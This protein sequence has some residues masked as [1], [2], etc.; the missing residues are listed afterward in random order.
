MREGELILGGPLDVIDPKDSFRTA[1]GHKAKSQLLLERGED[2]G[3][4]VRHS[5]VPLG[6]ELETDIK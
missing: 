5:S 1:T 6:S 4:G 2:R 3:A